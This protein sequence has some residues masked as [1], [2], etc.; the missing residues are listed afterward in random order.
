MKIVVVSSLFPHPQNPLSG[1]FVKEWAHFLKSQGHSVE[2]LF[3]SAIQSKDFFRKE[4]SEKEEHGLIVHSVIIHSRFYKKIFQLIPILLRKD[5]EKKFEMIESKAKVELINSHFIFPS[6]IVAYKLSQ[7][8]R[9]KHIISEHWSKLD[10]FFSRNYFASRARA[11][12]QNAESVICVSEFLKQNVLKHNPNLTN[13][14]VMPNIVDSLLF[15]FQEKKNR[16][17][18]IVFSAIASW[19]YPKRPQLFIEALNEIGMRTKKKIILKIGGDGP[20]LD[21][22]MEMKNLSIRINALGILNK[23]EVSDLMKQSDFFVHASDYETFCIVAAEALCCG[24]P[25]IASNRGGLPE[26]VNEES[27]VLVE[28][29][30][31]DWVTG[32]E[33]AMSR[34]F[35]SK[36]IAEQN[37]GRFSEQKVGEIFRQLLRQ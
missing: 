35:D 32:I 10:K 18:E 12:Y 23:Q 8:F 5:V 21:A 15:N 13:I 26:I 33:K 4:I 25:V 27:G 1:K 20:A 22:A 16:T 2:V 17:D 29:T 19:V 30:V 3:V 7:K 34:S 14:S 24:T 31:T 6:G 36:R 9:K 11:A 28:N 37:Q